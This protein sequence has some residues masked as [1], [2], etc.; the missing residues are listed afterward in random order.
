M[1]RSK[2][3]DEQIQH[4]IHA[5]RAGESAADVCN[6]LSISQKTL[7]R[8]RDRFGSI[9]PDE[10]RHVRQLEEENRAL[11]QE[12]QALRIDKQILQEVLADATLAPALRRALVREVQ[13]AFQVSE[14]RACDLLLTSRSSLRAS[15]RD[16]SD[17]AL[18]QRLRA[19]ALAEPSFGWRR[20]HALL[21]AEG[22]IVN[23][24]KVYRIY[25]E[26]GLI[27]RTQ[28]HKTLKEEQPVVTGPRSPSGPRW[29]A[30]VA[31]A[32]LADGTPVQVLAVLD[33]DQ[34]RCLAIHVANKFEAR[35]V[36]AAVERALNERPA[37]ATLILDADS[38]SGTQVFEAWAAQRRIHV[39]FSHPGRRLGNGRLIG[40]K[41]VL[42]HGCVELSSLTSVA[43]AEAALET[44][45]QSIDSW[46]IAGA[47]GSAHTPVGHSR[48]AVLND[49][50][51]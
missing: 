45:R 44:W 26:E 12:V 31:L 3:S 11:R 50:H 15:P 16:E 27:A 18:R 41:R 7:Y 10:M 37:P 43:D 9:Q 46:A 33:L 20:L 13:T 24:K 14:R 47:N 29:C 28:R 48:R 34:R 22:W 19:L 25:C 35:E 36:I 17:V 2:F 51:R 38:W 1:K 42:A 39:D 5:V 49:R 4:A 32:P 30:T 23:H 8:W 21:R 6:S 40:F